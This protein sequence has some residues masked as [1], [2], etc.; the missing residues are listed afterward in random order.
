[1]RIRTR[2]GPVHTNSGYAAI[3]RCLKTKRPI[4]RTARGSAMP[5]KPSGNNTA[6]NITVLVNEPYPRVWRPTHAPKPTSMPVQRNAHA[7][8]QRSAAVRIAGVFNSI[9]ISSQSIRRG[10]VT[11]AGNSGAVNQIP[12]VKARH[13]AHGA[14]AGPLAPHCAFF[15]IFAFPPP[16]SDIISVIQADLPIQILTSCWASEFNGV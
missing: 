5:S 10:A 2:R 8:H 16:T 15:P 6:S 11:M 3:R 7:L 14:V 12:G 13:E 9:T 4:S 1:M